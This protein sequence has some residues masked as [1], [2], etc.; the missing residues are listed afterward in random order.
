VGY[1]YADWGYG[2]GTF[3]DDGAIVLL[4]DDEGEITMQPDTEIQLPDSFGSP[5][6]LIAGTMAIYWYKTVGNIS[7]IISG[8]EYI[9]PDYVVMEVTTDPE[10]QTTEISVYGG[11]VTV[12]VMD[13]GKTYPIQEGSRVLF[14]PEVD[15]V[16]EPLTG[17]P[18]PE[19]EDLLALAEERMGAAPDELQYWLDPNYGEV[20]LNAGFMPDPYTVSIVSDGSVDVEP[21]ELGDNCVGYATSAPDFR[22]NWEGAANN[23]F[24]Y[25]RAED[26]AG[27]TVLIVNDAAA[28]WRCND[29]YFD[30]DP[31][32]GFEN[33]SPGQYDIWVSSYS[34]DV[35]VPGTLYITEIAPIE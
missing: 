34:S 15:P 3:L 29:D 32:V 5:L 31:L 28:Q 10:E 30:L 9:D 25:F 14:A 20:D 8:G 7:A 27:D 35:T 4:P 2:V 24:F 23:L 18:S 1:G 33:P 12:T 26:G 11:E 6:E 16:F 13:T 21:L 17:Q 19:I 22:V